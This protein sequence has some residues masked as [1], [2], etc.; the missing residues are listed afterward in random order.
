[1]TKGW[2]VARYYPDPTSRPYSDLDLAVRPD[3]ART[4]AGVLARLG[5]RGRLADLHVGLPDLPD[6]TW[7]EVFARTRVVPFGDNVCGVLAPADQFRLLAVHL[8]RHVCGRPLWLMDLAVLMEAA[9]PDA[10]WG[11]AL[12]GSHAWRRWLRAVAGLAGRLLGARVPDALRGGVP[13]W[14]EAQTLWRWGGGD[15]RGLS[16]LWSRPREWGAF[17]GYRLLNP[18]RWSYR[19]GLPPVRFLPAVWAA[20]VFGRVAQPY[21]RLWRKLARRWGPAGLPGPRATGHVKRA[22]GPTGRPLNVNE[23]SINSRWPGCRPR[24]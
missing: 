11:A 22:G 7:A 2:A 24:S 12:R 14:L 9:G 16:D 20:A 13:G 5:L 23:W 15:G 21:P 3:Q 19:L 1:M 4:A 10:D 8:V 6:R 18:V 17:V